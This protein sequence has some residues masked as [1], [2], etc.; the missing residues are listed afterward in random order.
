MRRQRRW[1]WSNLAYTTHELLFIVLFAGA[2]DG[3]FVL[4]ED[5]NEIHHFRKLHR[6]RHETIR[7]HGK[8]DVKF[9]EGLFFPTLT[10]GDTVVQMDVD[11]SMVRFVGNLVLNLWDCGGQVRTKFSLLPTALLRPSSTCHFDRH[12]S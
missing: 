7:S 3:P 6:E 4:W 8:N 5:V 2:V 1:L 10:S 9:G 11:Y 12:C